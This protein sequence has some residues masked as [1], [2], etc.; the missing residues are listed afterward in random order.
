MPVEFSFRNSEEDRSPQA[1]YQ[2]ALLNGQIMGLCKWGD[3]VWGF[4]I[5][6][7]FLMNVC[8]MFKIT[9]IYIYINCNQLLRKL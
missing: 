4:I 6:D 7:N 9:Y 1:Q 3:E 5:P 8:E 2:S